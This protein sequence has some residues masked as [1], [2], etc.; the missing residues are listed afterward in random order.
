MSKIFKEA[1]KPGLK[2]DISDALKLPP[3]EDPTPF[4]E[5]LAEAISQRISVE[6]QKYLTTN[7]QVE[8]TVAPGI[9]VATTGT[10]AAQTG[11]TTSPGRGVGRLIVPNPI[12]D[13]IATPA[14]SP[15]IPIE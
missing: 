12:I 2:D 15:T 8:V 9:T 10:P 13:P 7:I 4:A 14:P 11:T 1:I 6:L 3:S 5:R